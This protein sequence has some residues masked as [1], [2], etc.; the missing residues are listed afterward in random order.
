[1]K[2]RVVLLSCLAISSLVA[3]G[4]PA[5]GVEHLE[6]L[7]LEVFE[8]TTE[9]LSAEEKALLIRE[10]Q[11]G[12]WK[13]GAPGPAGIEVACERGD[14]RVTLKVYEGKQRQVLAVWTRN[15]QNAQLSFWAEE[16]GSKGL[17]PVE[18]MEE[19]ALEDFLGGA[20]GE[21]KGPRPLCTCGFEQDGTLSCTPS[22]WMEPFW[23]G[24]EIQY[25]LRYRWD[26]ERFVKQRLPRSNGRK[27]P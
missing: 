26:G 10:G 1:V 5:P 22:T 23:E 4:E 9:G 3:A 20:G 17:V 8:A 13:L 16:P 11:A 12:C 25:D 6:R 24:R 15:G 21:A 18:V 7:P 19:P 14:S 2:R 27:Q